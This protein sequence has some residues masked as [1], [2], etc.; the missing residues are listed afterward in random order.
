MAEMR[1]NSAVVCE[2]NVPIG[3]VTDTDMSLKSL[4]VVFQLLLQIK[5]CQPSNCP[6][7]CFTG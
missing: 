1:V 3:I 2:A 6:G 5:S 4:Q 7:K